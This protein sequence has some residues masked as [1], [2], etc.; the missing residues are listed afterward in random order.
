MSILILAEHDGQQLSPSVLQAVTAAKTWN[1][2]IHV[3][4]AGDNK[5]AESAAL[6]DGVAR[7]S[8]KLTPYT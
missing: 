5:V 1:L 3:L 7:A 8:F 2:P 6:I 4:V